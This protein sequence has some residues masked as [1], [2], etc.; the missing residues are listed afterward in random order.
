MRWTSSLPLLLCL[1][2]TVH[3]QPS[4]ELEAPPHATNRFEL[5][6]LFDLGF[7]LPTGMLGGSIEGRYGPV[8]LELGAGISLGGF[9]WMA[10]AWVHLFDR[11]STGDLALGLGYST[12]DVQSRGDSGGLFGPDGRYF[13]AHWLNISVCP[14]LKL[15]EAD[16][17]GLVLRAHLGAMVNLAPQASDNARILP[18]LGLSV[19]YAIGL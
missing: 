16:G 12:G 10:N 19:G 18:F 14:T 4:D 7:G 2:S 3:A 6:P 1:S 9:Q 17:S 13:P 5:I 11:M 15:A 8:G